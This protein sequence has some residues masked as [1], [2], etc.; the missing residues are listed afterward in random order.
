[1]LQ[2]LLAHDLDLEDAASYQ[3]LHDSTTKVK[4][5]LTPFIRRL[6]AHR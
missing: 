2:M 4:R 6:T 5:M 3:R 1:M